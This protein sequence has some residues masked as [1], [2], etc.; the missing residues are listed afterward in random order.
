[1]QM[2]IAIDIGNTQYHAGVFVSPKKHVPQHVYDFP[3]ATQLWTWVQNQLPHVEAI[4]CCSVRNHGMASTYPPEIAEKIIPFSPSEVLRKKQCPF[5]IAYYTP[6]TL[7]ADRLA[8][9][10]GAFTLYQ[11]ED[12]LIIDIGTCITYTLLTQR[13][14]LLG[15]SISPGLQ[16]RL[17]SL[18]EHTDQLPRLP[19][20]AHSSPLGRSTHTAMWAGVWQGVQ[21]EITGMIAAY[22]RLYPAIQ[23]IFCSKNAKN[24]GLG[25]KCS[26]FG[27]NAIL[28]PSLVLIGLHAYWRTPSMRT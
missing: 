27:V 2:I 26:T 20:N 16:M 19:L 5:P 18:H 4:V 24:L 6:H 3:N 23:V 21:A 28:I 14:G 25:T 12:C 7:G 10:I 13:E 9:A 1:M 15:G 22:Q 11:N 17:D 8:A